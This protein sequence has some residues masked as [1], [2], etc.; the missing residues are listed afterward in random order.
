M[1]AISA[2]GAADDSS[3]S[4][5]RHERRNARL[6]R[7]SHR[8]RRRG[9]L[10]QPAAAPNR[11]LCRWSPTRGDFDLNP[12]NRP[13][14]KRELKPAA[15]LVPLVFRHEPHVLLTQRTDHLSRHAGQVAFPG[16]RADPDDISLVETALRETQEETGI[17]PAFVTVAG[18]SRRL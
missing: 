1:R 3:A 17:E 10:A 15:V 16:G 6:D 11:R 14:E 8:Q 13:A 5:V 7:P 4:A 2:C 9:A 18:I 12:Q